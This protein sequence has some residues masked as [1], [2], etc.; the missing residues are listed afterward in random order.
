MAHSGTGVSLGMGVK[1]RQ[2]NYHATADQAPSN[3][4][5]M[6][7]AAFGEALERGRHDPVFFAEHFLGMPL[8][9]GQQYYLRN[10]NAKTNILVPANRWGKSYTVAIRHIHRITYKLIGL[11]ATAVSMGAGNP[12]AFAR[13]S[14]TTVS[15]APS[16]E[17]TKPVFDAILSIM[18]GDCIINEII[19]GV[20]VSRTNNCLLGWMLD[21]AHIRNTAPF[22]IPFHNNS[23]I[24]F[25]GTGEDQGKSIEGRSYGY[26][27]YDEAGQSGHL[28]FERE[29]RII[30]R[31]G[32]LDGP[33]DLVSTPEISSPSILEHY[34]MFQ[35]GGGEGNPC[36]EGFYSQEGSITDNHFYLASNPH[37]VE[38][39]KRDLGEDNP[40]YQ[41]IIHGK[42]VFGGDALYNNADILAAKDDALT[43]GVPYEEGHHYVVAVDTAMGRKDEMVF[44]VLDTTDRPFRIV[45]QLSERGGAKSPEVHMAD[46]VALVGSYRRVNNLHIIIETMNGESANFYKLMPGNLKS[47]TKCWGSWQ[48]EGLPPKAAMAMKRIK[49]Q[50]ILLAL[51]SLLASKDL[52]LPNEPTLI[53]Q[54]SI[55]RED[56]TNIPTDRVISLALACWLATDGATKTNNELIEIDF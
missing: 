25:R 32:E 24:L 2:T 4:S 49:K 11:G 33:L 48:P 39:M 53:K 44:T 19:D 29:R 14:Y 31:L 42:F 13:A 15:L 18:R 21:D 56:D 1:E 7:F 52:K 47:I 45:R 38:D 46:F 34:E 22:Y 55:Y 16:S 28:K 37:Y 36:E 43:L 27:S 51:R 12:K 9:D 20:K 17:L 41:Q 23:D 10:A 50:E 30:P 40:L 6:E 5:L 35:K 8:H 54:L 26:V 3:V